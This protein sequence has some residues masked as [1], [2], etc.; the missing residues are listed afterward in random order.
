M[1]SRSSR[2]RIASRRRSVWTIAD[3][4]FADAAHPPGTGPI[5]EV[6]DRLVAPTGG[7]QRDAVVALRDNF[8]DP[9]P[10]HGKRPDLLRI[11]ARQLGDAGER[12]G[13]SRGDLA[14]GIEVHRLSG[15]QIA[16]P[17]RLALFDQDAGIAD[18]DLDLIGVVDP[19]AM[20]LAAAGRPGGGDAGG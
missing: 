3:A 16:P 19:A 5:G 15:E 13:L 20:I 4:W 10:E 6:D 17:R 14:I 8:G 7:D 11:V 9:R 1:L 12:R 18:R 2:S